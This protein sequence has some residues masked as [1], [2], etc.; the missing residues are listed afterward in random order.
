VKNYCKNLDEVER[1]LF[2]NKYSLMNFTLTDDCTIYQLQNNRYLPITKEEY[3]ESG[4]I[5]QAIIDNSMEIA[6][7]ADIHYKE[8]Y[9][10]TALNKYREKFLHNNYY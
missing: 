10:R 5:Q 1:F 3:R 7:G 6:K 8:G 4:K 2:E 9:M